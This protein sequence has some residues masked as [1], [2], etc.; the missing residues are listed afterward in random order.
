MAPGILWHFTLRPDPPGQTLW[1]C[2]RCGMS[3]RVAQV[4]TTCP[5]GCAPADGPPRKDHQGWLRHRQ[6]VIG[7]RYP[8][9]EALRSAGLEGAG[10][11]TRRIDHQCPAREWGRL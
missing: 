10:T 11:V 9:Y 7:K 2:T 3:W 5:D 4:A 1:W 6:Q 8:E